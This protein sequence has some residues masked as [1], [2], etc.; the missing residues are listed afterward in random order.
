MSDATRPKRPGNPPGSNGGGGPKTPDVRARTNAN[1]IPGGTKHGANRWMKKSLAPA[2]RF[3]IARD[4]CAAYQDGGSCTLAE[5]YQEDLL[6]AVQA[7]VT[8]T[9]ASTPIALEY[10]KVCVA[11]QIIDTYLGGDAGN[12]FMPG[13]P[14]YIELQPVFRERLRL[15]ARMQD[16]ARELG[17]TPSARARLKA[18][19][20]ENAG[21]ILAAALAEVKRSEPVRE[22]E[23][24]PV[25]PEAGE[26]GIDGRDAGD[27][28]GDGTGD[29]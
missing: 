9:P 26:V 23:F 1:L 7:E 24:E 27:G 5:N 17:L 8:L 6:A 14:S 18:Q 19:E 25:T 10:A 4:K 22:G 2:C 21:D 16:L 3:C 15:S 20:R 13:Y 12:M 28:T 11:L 29:G